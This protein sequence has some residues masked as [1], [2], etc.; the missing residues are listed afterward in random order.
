M[1][2]RMYA[3]RKQIPLR[4]VQVR[5]RH[6]KIH[7]RDCATCET[8]TGKIDSIARHIQLEGNLSEE[9][10]ASLMAIADRCPVHRS[11][12]SEVRIETHREDDLS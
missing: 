12:H 7:A 4:Q 11:L 1:T 2:L 10:R 9:Q 3:E 6:E 8:E 5:L